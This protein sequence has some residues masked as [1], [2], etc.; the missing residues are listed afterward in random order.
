MSR[1]VFLD[2]DGVVTEAIVRGGRPYP[3]R[4]L[5]ELRIHPDAP[6]GL[7]ALKALGFLL[8]VVTNQPD[9]ARGTRTREAVEQMHGHRFFVCCHDDIDRCE[10]RKPAPGLILEA[11]RR[12]AIRLTESFFIG[13]RWRDVDAGHR[14][15]VRT[16][17]IDYGYRER[18]PEH[19][20]AAR[21]AS[22]R[23]A[24]DWI[25]SEVGE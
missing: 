13:D 3:P 14:A 18:A 20:P 11:A 22:L 5:G 4:T 6:P 8:V 21:V 16:V 1:A 9:V 12:H 24:V 2:R 10:C 19:A 7:A 25:R 23:E 17:F 15:G